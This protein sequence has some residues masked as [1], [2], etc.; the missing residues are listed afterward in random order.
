MQYWGEAK[1]VEK[2]RQARRD[3]LQTNLVK[4]PCSCGGTDDVVA[5]LNDRHGNVFNLVSIVQQLSVFSEEALVDEVM[6]RKQ[7]GVTRRS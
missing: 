3:L 6:T 4:L 1:K 5:T 7:A 2:Q